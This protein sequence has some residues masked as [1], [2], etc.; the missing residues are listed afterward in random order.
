MERDI[1][2]IKARYQPVRNLAE[3]ED[4][5]LFCQSFQRLETIRPELQEQYVALEICFLDAEAVIASPDLPVLQKKRLLYAIY[6]TY[7]R[8]LSEL[9]WPL[10][11]K[12]GADKT[13]KQMQKAIK[14]KKAP[15]VSIRYWIRFCAI[16]LPPLFVGI[17]GEIAFLDLTASSPP[18]QY[19]LYFSVMLLGFTA[20]VV[21]CY[22]IE[23]RRLYGGLHKWLEYRQNPKKKA[24]PMDFLQ[25]AKMLVPLGVSLAGALIKLL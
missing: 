3:T 13:I 22:M 16:C 23:G 21:A 25:T 2:Q 5:R 12:I 18:W 8:Q 9:S 10:R 15:P 11:R 4:F 20:Y 7:F 6:D 19:A 24:R 14:G 17:L 1:K